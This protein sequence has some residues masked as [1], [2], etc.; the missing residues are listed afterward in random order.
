[1]TKLTKSQLIK[2][3]DESYRKQPVQC[4]GTC[5]HFV[6]HYMVPHYS[7][8]LS[9]RVESRCDAIELRGDAVRK[10]VSYLG[11]CDLYESREDGA[12]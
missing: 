9:G 5:R 4:C 6:S 8:P 3:R 1:M 10:D 7:G 11:L 2:I 12:K